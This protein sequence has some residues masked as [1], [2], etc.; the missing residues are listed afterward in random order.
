MRADFYKSFP[1][2]LHER[3]GAPYANTALNPSQRKQFDPSDALRHLS[4][5]KEPPPL[6]E[7]VRDR[8]LRRLEVV[9]LDQSS[10]FY[11][12]GDH[13]V[14][15]LVLDG[16]GPRSYIVQTERCRTLHQPF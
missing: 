1:P 14:V 6:P 5:A 2:P 13:R 15:L 8:E 12:R 7:G 11:F 16:V 3:M 10:P 4:P 9:P